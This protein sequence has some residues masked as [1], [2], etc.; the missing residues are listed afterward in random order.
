L[1]L[2]EC[3]VAALIASGKSNAEIANQMVI[4]KRTVEKHIA[5]ILEKL[6]FTN[7]AQIVRWTLETQHPGSTE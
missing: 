7:R 5:H 6:G 1:T 4:S 2:R 3:E